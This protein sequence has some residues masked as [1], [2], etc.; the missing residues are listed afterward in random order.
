VRLTF[1]LGF[2]SFAFPSAFV[3]AFLIAFVGKSPFV[4]CQ[5]LTYAILVLVTALILAIAVFSL[6]LVVRGR[7]V[8]TRELPRSPR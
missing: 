4:G 6:R 7:A 8:A 2:W 5:A 3:G 1:S